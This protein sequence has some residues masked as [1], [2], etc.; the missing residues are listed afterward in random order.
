MSPDR[1]ILM[2]NQIGKFFRSQGRDQA[3]PGIADHIKNGTVQLII[4]TP[5]K[6]GPATDEG[7]IR[8]MAVLLPRPKLRMKG[9]CAEKFPW[10]A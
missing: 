2:A 8:S 7:K 9:C 10:P 4:N 6:K 3:V 5:T 1:L